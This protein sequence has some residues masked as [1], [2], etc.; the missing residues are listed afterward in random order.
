MSV[1][2]P[3]L[4]PLLLTFAAAWAATVPTVAAAD[5]RLAGRA[6]RSVHLRLPAPK[7]DAFYQEMTVRRSAPGTY[8]M[9]CGWSR[10]YFGIQELANG[11]KLAL[12][13]VWEPNAGQNP[14]LV[15]ADRRVILRSK[16]TESEVRR[17]G[18]EGTGG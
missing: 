6:C 9:A 8:F 3:R 16:G 10:G 2:A 1:V 12:F 13:S 7:A 5:E 14:D 15:P 11:K 4:F 18:G 17:F